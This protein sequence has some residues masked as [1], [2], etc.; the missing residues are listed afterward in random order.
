MTNYN[1]KFCCQKLEE[2]FEQL[3]QDLKDKLYY[4]KESNSV[5]QQ[6]GQQCYDN[7]MQSIISSTYERIL[8]ICCK[9]DA[10]K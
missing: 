1:R 6:D 4:C 2:L 9:L 7:F 8:R 3:D 10:A 5:E